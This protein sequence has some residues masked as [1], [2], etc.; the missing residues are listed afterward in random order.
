MDK[1][2]KP[3]VSIIMATYNWSRF[4]EESIYSIVNQSYTNRELIIVNDASNDNTKEI[5]SKFLHN[6]RI[7]LI[8]NQINLNV[9]K[10]RNKA[11]NL[12]KWKYIAVIDDDDTRSKDKL[13]I[14]VNFMEQN[15]DIWLLWTLWNKINEQW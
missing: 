1:N 15:S 4:I 2:I 6:E 13:A 7:Y 9:S 10:S 5:I 12:S 11:I 3:L 8:E 14:Q